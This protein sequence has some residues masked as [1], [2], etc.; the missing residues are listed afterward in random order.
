MLKENNCNSWVYSSPSSSLQSQFSTLQLSTFGPPKDALWGCL[1]A[2]DDKLT[3]SV[4][5]ELRHFG[6]EFYVSGIQHLMKRW[7]K[8][9]DTGDSQQKQHQLCKGCA[10]N[11]CIFHHHHH[12]HHHHQ[13]NMELGHF[14]T[15]SGLTGLEV[16]WMVS[17]SFFC[18]LIYSL[19][20]FSEIYYGA[21]CFCIFNYSCNHSFWEKKKRVITVVQPPILL[22]MLAI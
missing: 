22:Y 13:A 1:F 14:L 4:H 5:Q 17:S 12:H 18:L 6:Q 8:C 16:S 9:V 11:I 7:K 15:R 10:H 2:D 21:F 19:L 20:V 3:H